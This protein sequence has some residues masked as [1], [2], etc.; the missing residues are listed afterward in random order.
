MAKKEIDERVI[1][2][3]TKEGFTEL[4]WEEYIQKCKEDPE[5][6]VTYE[7]V[8]D[9]LNGLFFDAVGSHRYADY[10]SFQRRMY[11]NK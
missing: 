5:G 2:M 6:K 3:W 9:E 10:K 4:F 11:H 7:Q 8:F 1:R